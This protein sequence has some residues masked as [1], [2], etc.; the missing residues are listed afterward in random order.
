MRSLQKQ[1]RVQFKGLVDASLMTK[2]GI[3]TRD[4]LKSLKASMISSGLNM[5]MATLH[6]AVE[7]QVQQFVIFSR[8]TSP[9]TLSFKKIKKEKSHA[10]RRRMI[11]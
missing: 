2:F 1:K 6:K 11:N 4:D 9:Y 7:F 10:I 5:D 3:I 8:I